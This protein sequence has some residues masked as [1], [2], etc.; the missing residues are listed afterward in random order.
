MSKTKLKSFLISAGNSS[1]GPIGFCARIKAAS[2]E[3]A[4]ELAK[5]MLPEDMYDL[6]KTFGLDD[7]VECLN[8]YINPD[9]ITVADIPDDEIEDLDEED[10]ERDAGGAS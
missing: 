2:K 7:E 1:A 6:H 9:H 10:D 8:V 3:E 4:L 5:Q